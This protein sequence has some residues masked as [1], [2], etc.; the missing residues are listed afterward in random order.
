MR[1]AFKL[2]R[3]EPRALPFFATLTQSALGT[4]AGY[5]G[6]LLI[7]YDRY[8]SA[9]ALSLILAADLAPAML[10]GPVLGALADRFPRKRCAIAAD[11]IRALAFTGIALVDGFVATLALATLAGVG[12]GLFRPATL[13]AVPTLVSKRGVPAAMAVFGA[14]EDVGFTLGPALAAG[15]LLVVAPEGVM[16]LN[17]VTFG[18]SALVLTLLR[19]GGQPDP[20]PAGSTARLVPSL[21]KE[22]TEGMR[23]A[24]GTPGLRTVLICSSVTL[25]FCGMFNVAE[26]L[27]AREELGAGKSAFSLLVMLFGFGF[28]GGSLAG[29][30]GGPLPTLKRGYLAGLSL[31]AAGFIGIALSPTTEVAALT[32]MAAGVGN[33]LVLVHERLVIQALIP[34]HLMARL[35][36]VK[37]ALTAWAFGLAFVGGGALLESFGVRPV[38]LGAGIGSVLAALAAV[39][40]LRHVWATGEPSREERL[41][42]AHSLNDGRKRLTRKDRPDLV[43]A[44]DGWLALLDDLH[45]RPNY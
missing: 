20:S 30:N 44:G 32:F 27:F 26:L 22:A 40:A 8:E 15:L 3:T 39:V 16:V 4:G 14:I 17:G 29:A 42:L 12:T 7:A 37:D 36:G 34:D 25:T 21:I 13:A 33:G 45:Q 19:F 43:G 38:L 28:L 10:L 18:L 23:T 1:A 24:A 6:L 35:Y 9:W 41:S 5:I 11:L 31:L 2:F